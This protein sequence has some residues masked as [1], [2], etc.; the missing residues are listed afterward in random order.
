MTL[1]HKSKHML[2]R[3][4]VVVLIFSVMNAFIFNIALPLIQAEFALTSAQISWVISS[5]MMIYAIG[6]VLYG[7]LADIFSLRLL[8]Q[9]GL[10]ILAIGSLIG[11]FA[12]NYPMVIISRM[13]QAAGA[14]V[15]PTISM[16]VPARFFPEAERGR[17]IGTLAI[18]MALG[19]ALGPIISGIV[20]EIVNWR[21]LFTLSFIPLITLPLLRKY[22]PDLDNRT[23]KSIDYLGACF[24]TATI[25][26]VVLTIT[27][28]SLTFVALF[29][30]SAILLIIRINTYHTPIVVPSLFMNK[31]YSF[32]LFITFLT[33]ALLFALTFATPLFLDDIQDLTPLLIGLVLFPSAVIAALLGKKAGKL[34]DV[35]GNSVVFYLSISCLGICYLL[36]S[37]FVSIHPI[38][39][40]IFLIFGN[41]G[42]TFIRVAL[43]NTISQTLP[44]ES[45][46]IGMGFFTMF[47]FIA[48]AVAT[49]VIGLLLGTQLFSNI[50]IFSF[51]QTANETRYSNVFLILTFTACFTALLYM[52]IRKTK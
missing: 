16:I 34:A 28:Y 12:L 2:L 25:A 27:N 7:K 22:L 11:L 17:A 31:R 29:A 4:L 9:I 35:F 15:I 23:S 24:L 30:I 44:K 20:A 45:L 39:I 40:A 10:I 41:I 3:V 21:L 36:L 42:V 48:G 14:A 8:I 38:W 5:Y 37:I 33:A 46:G 13:L 52:L 49:S 51:I 18:G 26:F 47:N 6:T 50:S 32:M 19:T 1:T 43:T